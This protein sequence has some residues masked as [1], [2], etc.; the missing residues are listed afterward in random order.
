MFIVELLYNLKKKIKKIYRD[1]FT[2]EGTY[3]SL[4]PDRI[5]IKKLYKKR[6]GKELDLKNPTTY[7]EKLNWLKLYDR[8][9]EYTMMVDKY[10]V[11]DFVK[12]TIGEKYLIPLIGSWNSVEEIEFNELPDK[13]VLK[14]NHDNGVII[15]K[16]KSIL[17]IEKV[18]EDLTYHL[19]RDYYKKAREWPYKNVRR[20]II[21]E[22]Y[23]E[24][25][26]EKELTD[27][28]FF[29]FGGEPKVVCII[30]ARSSE[31]TIDFFDMD[32]NH[33]TLKDKFPN[34][35][36]KIDKPEGFSEMVGIA[37]K[38]SSGIPHVRIDLYY[39]NGEVYFGEITFYDD[40]GY[41]YKEPA[42]WERQLSDWIVLP[43][44]RI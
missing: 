8:C 44:K 4:L 11:R 7:N 30:K 42:T 24:D 21:C 41:G 35:N 3:T 22:K 36:K 5:Y 32:F 33:L 12:K 14:C 18:K 10:A 27:Y 19:S 13:F 39:I 34:A 28:K 6:M 25:L 2:V 26:N 31:P 16:N 43:K 40:A 20:K 37:K 29:C 17:D 15:C 38:L 1:Y 23:M 9:P